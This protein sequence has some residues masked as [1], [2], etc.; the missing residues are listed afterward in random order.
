MM[1]QDGL[2]PAS[3][4]FTLIL[5]TIAQVQKPKMPLHVTGDVIIIGGALH[6]T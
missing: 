3:V 5:V 4:R 2:K 1:R 6:Y